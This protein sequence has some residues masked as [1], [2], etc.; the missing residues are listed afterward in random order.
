M[1]NIST[2]HFILKR[3]P[4][5]W[6]SIICGVV[7]QNKTVSWLTWEFKM[8]T[9]KDMGEKKKENE[10]MPNTKTKIVIKLPI[11]GERAA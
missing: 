8:H 5:C 4:F 9:T 1:E 7:A 2:L 6:V 10:N 11:H 3:H